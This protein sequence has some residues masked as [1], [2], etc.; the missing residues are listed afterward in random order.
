MGD[1]EEIHPLESPRVENSPDQQ[2]RNQ[3]KYLMRILSGYLSTELISQ[4]SEFR[5][6][7]RA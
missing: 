2:H 4:T 3:T 5:G 6:A 7:M 1:G